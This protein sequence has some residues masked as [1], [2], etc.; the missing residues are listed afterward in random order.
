[1]CVKKLNDGKEKRYLDAVVLDEV[2]SP[3]RKAIQRLKEGSLRC[4]WNHPYIALMSFLLC[5]D[6]FFFF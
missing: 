3:A 1:M 4:N 6:I 2:I 5:V